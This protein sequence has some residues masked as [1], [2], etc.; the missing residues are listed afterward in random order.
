MA[1]FS[2]TNFFPHNEVLAEEEKIERALIMCGD[3]GN[4]LISGRGGWIESDVESG[5]TN[6]EAGPVAQAPDEKG[7]W[8]Y[9]GI[10]TA[11]PVGSWEDPSESYEPDYSGGTWRR[12]TEEELKKIAVGDFTFF[13][14]HRLMEGSEL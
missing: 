6:D 10:P 8:I 2:K 7:L 4:V 9:E 14:K 5:L 1:E 11:V 3:H 12:P 13:G